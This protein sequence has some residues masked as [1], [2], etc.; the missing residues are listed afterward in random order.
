MSGDDP[1]EAARRLWGHIQEQAQ[2]VSKDLEESNRRDRI[3]HMKRMYEREK[4]RWPGFG[5]PGYIGAALGAFLVFW[6]E[7][8]PGKTSSVRMG[9]L[10]IVFSVLIT[11]YFYWQHLR[12]LKELKAK[13]DEAVDNSP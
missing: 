7:A 2:A 4:K 9:L 1:L 3:A 6:P 10:L 13:Y 5:F 11:G 8:E 12:K